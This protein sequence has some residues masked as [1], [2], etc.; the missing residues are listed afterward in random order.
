MAGPGP[1]SA[2]LGRLNAAASFGPGPGG[3]DWPRTARFA[4]VGLVVHGPFFFRGFRWLDGLAGPGGALPRLLFRATGAGRGAAAAA[5]A[6][7]A[8][9]SLGLGVRLFPPPPPGWQAPRLP[10]AIFASLAGQATLFPV[11][12]TL[13]VA[14]LAA[15]DG[16]DLPL[17]RKRFGPVVAADAAAAGRR[18]PSRRASLPAVDASVDDVRGIASAVLRLVPPSLVAGAFFWPAVNVA[19]YLWVP[20]AGR[21]L[22]VNC[23]G[24]VWQAY[25]SSKVG[26]ETGGAHAG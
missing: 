2:R 18:A 3:H 21:V 22:Y 23:A 11:Y 10:L 8:A 15:L 16:A 9:A 13:M 17:P 1:S 14:S 5:A 6:A 7:P 12:L 19:N 20:A 26:A 24:V 25:L 4:V